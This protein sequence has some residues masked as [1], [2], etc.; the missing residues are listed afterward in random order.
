[1][2]RALLSFI[3]LFPL[4]TLAQRTA[5]GTFAIS[6]IAISP[7]ASALGGSQVASYNTDINQLANNPGLFDSTL[8][9][10]ASLGYLNYL[11]GLN[12]AS[13]AYGHLIDSIGL[14]S[15]YLRYF[16]YGTFQ[17][18]D[19]SGN[20]IGQFK[21][22]DYEIGVSLTRVYDHRFSYGVTLKQYFSS[23][24]QYFAYGV[25]LDVGGF[26]HNDKGFA[27]GLTIDD[28]GVKL[29]DYTGASNQA[30]PFSMNVGMSKKFSKA[31]LRFGLQYNHLEQWDL[32]ASDLDALGN[33]RVDLLTGTQQRRVVT[34]DNLA[35]HLA[36]TAAFVPSETFNLMIGYDFRKQLE[37][38][39]T[40]RP[41]LVGFSFGAFAKIKR[42]GLQYAI[43]S[44]HLGGTSN[45]VAITTNLAEWRTKKTAP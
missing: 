41:G 39:T 29:V 2:Q 30:L 5:N 40:E 22:A 31:P 23:M 27:A 36:V 38:G 19:V 16:D 3:L 13:L 17:E 12:Q 26:Y 10:A 34:V 25:A 43:S 15:G 35:R 28:I 6:R 24:Y 1:M 37:L 42:F 44:Y 9:Q 32:A 7:L 11:T 4:C 8:H 33:V 20:E 14:V 45:H 18:T 21:A